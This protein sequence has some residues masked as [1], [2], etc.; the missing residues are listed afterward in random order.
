MERRFYTP[1]QMLSET[2]EN[3][4]T[5]FAKYKPARPLDICT[6]CC[7]TPEAEGQLAN[8]NVRQIPMELLATYNDG[9]KPEKT[10][11]DEVKHFLPRYLDLIGQFQFPTH[12][13]ELSLSRL[14]PFEAAEWT[15]PE[16]DL[17]QQYRTDYFKYC[18]SVY[19]IPSFSDRI[20]TILIMFWLAG[21]AI[22]DLLSIW[23]NEKTQE[24]A[25]HFRDLYLHGFDPYNPSKLFNCFGDKA[26]AE[27]LRTWLETETVKQHFAGTIEGLILAENDLAE[28]DMTDLNILYDILRTP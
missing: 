2:I 1:I 17:L 12:S 19:P 20:D 9:A 4:Y 18:L 26:L 8:A 11:I 14:M 23:E 5:L 10:R 24:S 28:S 25:L 15:M 16:L 21:F 13:S 22:G 6:A 7:M 3:A 27:M